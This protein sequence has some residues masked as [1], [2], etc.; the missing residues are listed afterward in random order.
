MNR[1]EALRERV[2]AVLD[3]LPDADER[4]MA[5]V[6]LYGVAQAAAL[7]A[8][9]RGEDAELAVAAALLHDLHTYA[10]GNPIDHAHHGA[11]LAGEILKGLGLFTDGEIQT[12]RLAI[13]RHSDKAVAHRPFDEL[14]KDADV[15]QHVLYNPTFGL[16]SY[17][18]PRF[19]A[20]LRELGCRE[21]ANSL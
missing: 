9:R 8:L 10:T 12:I 20:V 15:L 13:Y 16:S 19:E 4:R 18:R 6:H 14:I 2:D 21:D 17:E 7:L 1:I 11:K 5:T 3:R